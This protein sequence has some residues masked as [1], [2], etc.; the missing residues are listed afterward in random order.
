MECRFFQA[1]HGEADGAVG[2]TS[3]WSES[4][5]RKMNSQYLH[6]RSKGNGR[7]GKCIQF[8]QGSR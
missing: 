4:Y 7:K 3:V 6:D 2:K 5:S 1:D 8:C